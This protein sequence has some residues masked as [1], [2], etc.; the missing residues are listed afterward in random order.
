MIFKATKQNIGPGSQGGLR[1]PTWSV[2]QAFG[3]QQYWQKTPSAEEVEVMMML[4][5]NHDAKG[6]TYWIYP[7]T[8]SV[9]VGSGVLGKVLQSEPAIDFLFGTNAIK[10]LG[11]GQLDV[12]VWIL[13]DQ[14]M[15]G[16]V[17]GDYVDSNNETTI[18]LPAYVMSINQSLYG[19]SNWAV[20]GGKV[21]NLGLR[22]LE[23]D[24]LVVDIMYSIMLSKPDARALGY[25]KYD[26]PRTL[27]GGDFNAKHD[28]YEPGVLSA[29]QGATLSNWSQD[30][31]MD[32]IGECAGIWTAGRITITQVTTIPGRG[33]PPNKRVGYRVTE[34]GLYTFASLIESGA[35]WLPKVRHIAFGRRARNSHG[36]A[37]RPVPTGDTDR[38]AAASDRARS[39]PWWTNESASAYSLYKR[40]GKT[41]EDRKRMLSATRKA[42]RE[43]WRRL[44]DS[45]SDD[46]DLYKVVGW[47]QSGSLP[48]VPAARGRRPTDRRHEGESTGS[49]GQS[50]A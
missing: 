1:K 3:E 49:A 35:Y 8:D 25:Q 30:T 39:A 14:M 46:A 20:S 44:I 18:N 11:S 47:P 43:Y 37:H 26:R 21:S 23:V 40:S 4:S 32:F 7:S 42:K 38:R 12:S 22:G 28:T 33:T 31:G 24:I 50:T 15:V 27:V 10:G 19:G 13:E 45:A 16:I 48:Q 34:D 5:V 9:N 17:N 29:T 6:I 2:V 36:A 41:L